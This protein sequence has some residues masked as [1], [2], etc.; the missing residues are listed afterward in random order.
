MAHRK[1]DVLQEKG[2]VI[3]KPYEG[4]VDP[5]EWEGLTSASLF[6]CLRPNFRATRSLMFSPPVGWNLVHPLDSRKVCGHA[7]HF[8]DTK[9]EIR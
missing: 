9:W 1:L 2:F 8:I 5:S 3:L 6:A 7:V 4:D